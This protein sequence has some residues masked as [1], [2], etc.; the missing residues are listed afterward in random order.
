[1]VGAD[2]L[3]LVKTILAPHQKRS[4]HDGPSAI[5]PGVYLGSYDDADSFG[6]LADL[7]ITHVVNCAPVNG[8]GA[9]S[10]PG[11]LRLQGYC[12]IGAEDIAG[13]NIVQHFGVVF[14]FMHRALEEDGKVLVYCAK[15]MNRSAAVCVE[16]LMHS[17]EMSIAC[18]VQAVAEARGRILTNESFV[19]QLCNFEATRNNCV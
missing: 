12:E 10:F 16:Y 2:P 19:E 9:R 15:G 5:C 8:F 3:N 7:G 13:Y 14:D 11:E 6:L 4:R 17:Q 18:A 1:M